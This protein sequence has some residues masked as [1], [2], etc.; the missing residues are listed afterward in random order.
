MQ[1]WQRVGC[2]TASTLCPH[3]LF[4]SSELLWVG[5]KAGEADMEVTDMT[6]TGPTMTQEAP[7]EGHIPSS[8]VFLDL[9]FPQNP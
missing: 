3:L 4:H 7:C 2:P 1:A 6:D 8:N 5:G 9:L